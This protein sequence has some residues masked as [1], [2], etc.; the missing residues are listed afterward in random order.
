MKLNILKYVAA[1]FYL[2]DEFNKSD[3]VNIVFGIILP[4]LYALIPFLYN[5]IYIQ[6]W[7]DTMYSDDV[8]TSFHVFVAFI[9]TGGLCV[10]PFLRT[11]LARIMWVYAIL[12]FCF[13][14]VSILSGFNIADFIG[15]DG[16][17]N[18]YFIW[19]VSFLLSMGIVLGNEKNN[20]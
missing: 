18:S 13:V 17:D 19:A 5:L 8:I 2:R 3:I 9:W 14:W 20:C 1:D 10:I 7:N 15:L 12:S 11:I 16:K 6:S 4:T